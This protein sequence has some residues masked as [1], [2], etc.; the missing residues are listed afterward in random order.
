MSDS[1]S[2]RRNELLRLKRFARMKAKD[3]ASKAALYWSDDPKLRYLNQHHIDH[4][5]YLQRA[6]IQL[7]VELELE[8][9]TNL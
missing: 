7:E 4:F 5:Q 1:I 8:R 9:K 2:I 3:A 6:W